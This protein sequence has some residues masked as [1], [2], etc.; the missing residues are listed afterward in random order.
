MATT[1]PDAGAASASAANGN[2]GTGQAGD[3]KPAAQQAPTPT[4]VEF[5]HRGKSH[6]VA[7]TPEKIREAFQKAALVDDKTSELHRDPAQFK[8]FKEFQAELRSSPTLEEAM[9]R[10]RLNPELVLN[11]LRSQTAPETAVND[12]NEGGAAQ[13]APKAQD[14]A[15][16]AEIAALR[17]QLNGLLQNQAQSADESAV[18][19][20]IA[21][22]APLGIGKKAA[23]EVRDFVQTRR[24]LGDNSPVSVLVGAKVQSQ[25]EIEQERQE[26][27]LAHGKR[28]EQFATTNPGRGAP[29]VTLSKPMTK[30]SFK[31]GELLKEAANYARSF[32]GK[33]S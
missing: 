10:A 32:F 28:Q 7:A 27:K 20:E 18:S 3:Q 4:E 8:Q 26:A 5:T 11:A 19:A 22:L 17:S 21:K 9:T 6:R 31:N 15:V 24:A 1:T 14:P 13:A 16:Q 23:E 29:M 33:T 30:D 25:L 2:E 12:G